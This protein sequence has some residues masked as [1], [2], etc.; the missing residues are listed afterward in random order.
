[1]RLMDRNSARAKRKRPVEA[2]SLTVC[3]VTT[4]FIRSPDDGYAR[5]VFEQARSL[6]LANPSHRIRVVAPHAVGLARREVI[7][8]VEVERFRY[9]FPE[10]AQRLAYRHEGLFQSVSHSWR[11][12]IQLP[13]F[14]AAMAWRSWMCSKDCDVI[15]AQWLTVLLVAWPVARLRGCALCVSIRG[16]DMN[17]RNRWV[18]RVNRFL[19]SRVDRVLPVSRHLSQ[20]VADSVSEAAISPLFNGVDTETFRPGDRSAAR[21]ALDLPDDRFL[22]LCIGGLIRRKGIDTLIR[23]LARMDS[24]PGPEPWVL[25]VGSG[26]EAQT[27]RR[28]AVDLD[29]VSQVRFLGSQPRCVL[30]EL[31]DAADVVVLPSHSEGRPNVVLE[32]L[33]AGRPLIAT[34]IPGTAELVRENETGLLFAPGDAEA[35]AHHLVSVRDHPAEAERLA[36]AGRR[37]TLQKGLSWA[38]HGRRLDSIYRELCSRPCAG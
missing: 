8:G 20:R 2:A 37:D 10:R 21:A 3:I 19:L 27:L 33:A 29:V 9:A 31:L 38:A 18:Q 32:A 14:L 30:P 24:E 12:A 16:A 13:A 26:P 23:A 1:M 28:L 4:S 15:H 5:F 17:V 34:A 36:L 11:I 7:E 6:L 25:L 35:L 22:V